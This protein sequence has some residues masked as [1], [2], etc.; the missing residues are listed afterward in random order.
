MKNEPRTN[1]TQDPT[2]SKLEAAQVAGPSLTA[3][4]GDALA[5]EDPRVRVKLLR[6]AHVAG[7]LK[8]AGSIVLVGEDEAVRLCREYPGMFDFFGELNG[9]EL[10]P[11]PIVKAQRLEA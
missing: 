5:A 6:D 7:E 3:A 8:K 11:K 9:S 10:A 1:L 2:R 4:P